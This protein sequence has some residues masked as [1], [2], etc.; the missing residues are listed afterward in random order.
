M[1]YFIP[2][3]IDS[4]I[5]EIPYYLNASAYEEWITCSIEL[6]C[7][8]HGWEEIWSRHI[9]YIQNIEETD[10]LVVSP[11]WLTGGSWMGIRF[12]SEAS[13]MENSDMTCPGQRSNDYCRWKYA[14]NAYKHMGS[15][16][17][18][19][20]S[21]YRSI[22]VTPGSLGTSN[23][24]TMNVE[25][26]KNIIEKTAGIT[27]AVFLNMA[28]GTVYAPGSY[29][30]LTVSVHWLYKGLKQGGKKLERLGIIV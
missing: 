27:P 15:D 19:L 8:G 22:I 11:A 12:D 18:I 10:T 20:P 9:G 1:L 24:T 2:D 25:I 4:V 3:G 5:V 16:Q 26:R 13:P 28:A 7:T 30:I 29:T 17:V 21:G 6:G 14:C 23:T